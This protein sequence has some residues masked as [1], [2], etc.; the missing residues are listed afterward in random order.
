MKNRFNIKVLSLGI[1]PM[2]IA[3]SAYADE[4]VDAD[5]A[6]KLARSE[7][8][9]RCHGETKKKEGP[10]YAVIAAFYR[11]NKDAEDAIY[12]HITTGPKVKLTDGHKEKHKAILDKTPEQIRNLVR[13]MLAH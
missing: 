6:I 1:L 11:S 3:F 2:M 7:S 4:P 5:A 13:W 12:E 10:S 9:L 8:C